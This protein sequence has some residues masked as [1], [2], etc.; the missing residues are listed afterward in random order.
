M[1]VYM[2][3]MKSELA[4]NL[5]RPFK[6]P[7]RVI[8]TY[9]NGVGVVPM[10]KPAIQVALNWVWRCP[11]DVQPVGLKGSG[12]ISQ[13]ERDCELTDAV[14]EDRGDCASPTESSNTA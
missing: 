8:D 1:F 4:Q 14:F 2:P 13:I 10:D 12:C 6:G 11:D 5:A 7:F 3:A 9:P